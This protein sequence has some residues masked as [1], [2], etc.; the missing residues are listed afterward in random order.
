[1]SSPGERRTRRKVLKAGSLLGTANS[2]AHTESED[3]NTNVMGEK[4]RVKRVVRARPAETPPKP[5]H[6][7]A[8]FTCLEC[9]CMIPPSTDRCPKCNML[10]VKNTGESNPPGTDRI[11]ESKGV[12]RAEVVSK[13]E[14]AC[15]NIDL[16]SDSISYDVNRGPI[17]ELEVECPGC[18]TLVSFDAG[19]CPLCGTEVESKDVGL[20]SLFSGM[21]FDKVRPSEVGCPLCGEKA[22]L[23]N[24]KCPCCG[25]IVCEE[26]AK[27][28]I[29]KVEPVVHNENVVFIHLDVE[30]GEVNF[31][32]KMARRLGFEQLTLKL[33]DIGAR[34][35]DREADLKSTT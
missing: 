11:E 28:S 17:P 5:Q 23:D 31:L 24:G 27:D 8:G 14:V 33:N 6:V 35:F 30:S 18:G 3:A 22:P 4:R 19:K 15:V 1:M 7:D 9:G 12:A 20:V 26:D 32:Q 21:E 34:G 29:G 16:G 13:G 10:Y 2:R 25:A